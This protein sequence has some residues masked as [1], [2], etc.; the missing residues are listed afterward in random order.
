M[1]DSEQAMRVVRTL[2]DL[3]CD[4][5]L[6]PLAEGIDDPRQAE[7]LQALGCRLGQGFLYA[8]PLPLPAF[9]AWFRRQ[10]GRA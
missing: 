8:E 10:A 1:F 4:L 6:E 9:V 7:C 5:G 2:V 3:A